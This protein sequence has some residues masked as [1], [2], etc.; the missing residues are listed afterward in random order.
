MAVRIIGPEVDHLVEDALVLFRHS[1]ILLGPFDAGAVRVDGVVNGLAQ[2]GDLLGGEEVLV[3][4]VAVLLKEFGV[5]WC[6]RA[7]CRHEG[8]TLLFAV[9]IKHSTGSRKWPK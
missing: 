3:A 4:D 8:K 9:A 2:R 5:G 7:H 1:A 6:C